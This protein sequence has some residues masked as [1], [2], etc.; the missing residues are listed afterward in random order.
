MQTWPTLASIDPE[1]VV[2]VVE[3]RL[4]GSET[5]LGAALA[6]VD[7]G[8]LWICAACAQGASA[9]I[10]AFV[11]RYVAP[12]TGGL[13]AMGL[14]P[15]AIDDIKQRVQA[16]LL[17]PGPDG[18]LRV[19]EYAGGGRL[20]GLVKVV[21]MRLAV[22]EL[23]AR[24]HRPERKAT[25]DETAVERLMANELGP[26]M[27]VLDGQQRELVK[28]AFGSAIERL[29]STDRGILRLHLLER[30]SIDQIAALHDVHRATAARWLTRLRERLGE[31]TRETLRA[32]LGLKPRE[33]DS[34]MYAVRS[35]LDL[36]L[37]RVLAPSVDE[38][39]DRDRP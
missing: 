25:P 37:S 10:G 11:A 7:A 14:D 13:R 28:E 23:R 20:G 15:P 4:A 35:R 19:L 29:S 2:A 12:L 34:L 1:R 32:Q 30:L 8:E 36:S 18:H 39:P 17:T 3:Q 26:E 5:S 22:D 6:N 16:K 31:Y 33:L 21:A 9:A 38:P 27:R 24:Q